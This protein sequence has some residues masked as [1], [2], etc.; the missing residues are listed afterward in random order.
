M[1][2][3]LFTQTM[4]ELLNLV[5]VLAILFLVGCS[6]TSQG[7]KSNSGSGGEGDYKDYELRIDFPLNHSNAGGFEEKFRMRGHLVRNGERVDEIP[8]EFRIVIGRNIAKISSTDPSQWIL[9]FGLAKESREYQV[10]LFIGLIKKDSTSVSLSNYPIP[11][12]DTFIPVSAQKAYSLAAGNLAIIEHDL[13]SQQSRILIDVSKLSG[14]RTCS[15]IVRFETSD[16]GKNLFIICDDVNETLGNITYYHYNVVNKRLSRLYSCI[17]KSPHWSGNYVISGGMDYL[18]LCNYTDGSILWVQLHHADEIRFYNLFVDHIA[19]EG[20]NVVARITGVYYDQSFDES[21]RLNLIGRFNIEEIKSNIDVDP[22]TITETFTEFQPLKIAQLSDINFEICGDDLCYILGDSLILT[23]LNSIEDT[24]DDTEIPL[25]D[26]WPKEV[27]HPGEIVNAING[28]ATLKSPSGNAYFTFNHA[29]RSFEKI[30]FQS[31]SNLPGSSTLEVNSEGNS[32]I[33]IDADSR[34]LIYLD[35]ENNEIEKVID[36]S[37][38]FPFTPKLKISHDVNWQ[39][40]FMYMQVA[41]SLDRSIMKLIGFDL[42]DLQ[43]A[44]ILDSSDLETVA[45]DDRDY[46]LGQVAGSS[47]PSILWFSVVSRFPEMAAIENRVLEYNA[48]DDSIETLFVSRTEK[49]S[50]PLLSDYSDQLGGVVVS[51]TTNGRLA[52]LIDENQLVDY[53]PAN[54]L[55]VAI[56]DPV[57]NSDF[58]EV[59]FTGIKPRPDFPE[60]HIRDPEL[61]IYDINKRSVDT[62]AS[63]EK[64]LGLPLRQDSTFQ[65]LGDSDLL[66]DTYFNHLMYLDR[67]TGDRVLLPIGD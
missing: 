22:Y 9:E 13:V 41:D 63:S 24:S 38:S 33:T 7:N 35:L 11:N 48:F 40:Q 19:G 52:L 58:T 20:D 17:Q 64:G 60:G 16:D 43:S 3:Q 61:A 44:E 55:Y 29:S 59:L 37:S 54:E 27:G 39:Q 5:V 25:K 23:P 21:R 67:I 50:M 10:D 32:A 26:L 14:E 47:D 15:Y 36:L 57:L 6:G 4:S 8:K 66:V 45:A 34:E 62:I 51:S 49:G 12:R 2:G 42:V 1:K 30:D 28:V 31:L 18:H 56:G 46:I 65:F 53:V